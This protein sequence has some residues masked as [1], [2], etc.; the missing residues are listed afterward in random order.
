MEKKRIT[1]LIPAQV[2]DEV[3]DA[4][5]FLAGHPTYLAVADFGEQ[6]C[7]MY[8]AYL[9]KKHHKDLPFPKRTRDPKR[10][11]PIGD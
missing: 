11:R 8:L 2:A 4:V 7:R 3:R 9:Q 5:V 10:G 1:F 6:A